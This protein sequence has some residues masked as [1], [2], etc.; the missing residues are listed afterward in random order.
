MKAVFVF[1]EGNHDVT[2]IVR[3]I[4]NVQKE[5]A[6]WVG[7]PIGKL[8]SPLGPVPIRPIR[9]NPRLKA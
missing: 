9:T 4:G 5:N 1:C 3:S 8:P 7:D 2:F 6:T